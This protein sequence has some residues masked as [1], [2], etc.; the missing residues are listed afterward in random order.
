MNE[1]MNEER[2]FSSLLFSFLVA[3]WRKSSAMFG[4]INISNKLKLLLIIPL[5]SGGRASTKKGA[6]LLA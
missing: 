3:R 6:T 1:R 4:K 2:N 5:P